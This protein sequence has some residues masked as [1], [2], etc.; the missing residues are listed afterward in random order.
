MTKRRQDRE[1]LRRPHD[2]H[3]ADRRGHPP[4]PRPLQTGWGGVADWYDRLVGDRGSEYHQRVIIPGV[5]RMLEAGDAK[6]G[7]RGGQR[8]VL[9]LACGQGVLCRRLAQ[10]GYEVTGVDAARELIEAARRR[11]EADG[12]SIRYLVADVTNLAG[13][14]GR[15]REGIG[16][17]SY[18]AATIVLAVQNVSP[19]S[20]VWRA[21]RAALKPG[22][23]LIVVMVHPCFRV[24]GQSHWHWDETSGTH[25][26][27]VGG[28]LTSGR[29]EIKTHPGLAAHGKDDR[30]TIHFHRPLQAYVNT[31][32][33]AG[34]LIDHLEE[35]TSHRTSTPGRREAAFDRVR[36]EIPLF[37]ALRARKV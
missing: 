14:R 6:P 28:Y 18:D 17:E 19:L 32:G 36:K 7:A 26:R 27:L 13:E 29:V 33:N 8:R 35:W 37:L 31:L 20:P 23:R 5:L 12:L 1:N 25:S 15:L 34:L 30:A 9:D 21:C 4:S 10:E 2:R 22:G 16:P 11:S 24:P 3:A